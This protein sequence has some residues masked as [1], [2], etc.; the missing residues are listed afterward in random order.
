MQSLRPAAKIGIVS[1]GLLVAV[2]VAAWLVF[3]RMAL[4]RDGNDAASSGMA[5]FGD[6]LLGL[7]VF[8]VLALVPGGLGLYWLRPVT[9]IWPVLVGSAVALALTGVL[10]VAANG[11]WRESAG[12]LALLADVRIGLMPLSAL[13]SLCGAAFAPGTRWRWVLIG[14]AVLDGALFCSV[15]AVHFVL[16][17]FG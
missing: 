12:N 7:A 13:V 10:A 8:G 17:R 5:A 4:M 6:L 2:A 11:W 16:P 14:A 15:M 3:G 1:G 9:W